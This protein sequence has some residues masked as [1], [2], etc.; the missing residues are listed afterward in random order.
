MEKE[1]NAPVKLFIYTFLFCNLLSEKKGLMKLHDFGVDSFD[2]HCSLRENP[3]NLGA[4]IT[5]KCSNIHVNM[6]LVA[7]VC[8]KR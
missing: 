2:P 5:R 1:K 7:A 3:M 8:A 6:K 4:S